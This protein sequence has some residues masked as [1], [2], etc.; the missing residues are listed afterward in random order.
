MDLGQQLVQGELLAVGLALRIPL[1]LCKTIVPTNAEPTQLAA[2]RRGVLADRVGD[3][4]LWRTIAVHGFDGAALLT[5]QAAVG[6]HGSSTW[7]LN[8]EL[9]TAPGPLAITPGAFAA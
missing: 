6:L 2:R 8:H 9:A 7:S 1:G 3:L 5:G 4:T